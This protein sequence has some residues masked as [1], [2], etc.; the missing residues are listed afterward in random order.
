MNI[1]FIG[2]FEAPFSTENDRKWSFRML[3]H[4]V[5]TFQENKT[6]P[7]NLMDYVD[8]LDLL[9]YSHTHGWEIP[10]LEDV[11]KSFK[12]KKVP[13]IS[14]HL[15]RWAWL[16]RE[17]D[18]GKEATWKVDH[19]FMADAS[20]EAVKLYEKVGVNWT[21]LKPGVS[22]KYCYM[23]APDPVK[24]PH[25]IIFVG[26]YNYHKEYP[27]RPQLIDWLKETYGDRFGHYGGGGGGG[28][29]PTV[30]GHDLNT[31]YATAKIVVGDSC[32]AGRPYYVSDRYY[33]TR[34][35]GGF[36]LHPY[37]PGI[38]NKGVVN[39]KVGDFK[40]LK[41]KIDHCLKFPKARE[42]LRKIGFN[43]VKNN[44]TYTHRAKEIID[45]INEKV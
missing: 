36:L 23:S 1:G 5:V 25:E 34:G 45:V 41:K 40:D 2:N 7:Q 27:F 33:E 15:D 24:Y 42:K 21:W 19:M 13:V 32:F 14:V 31:L 43:R 30:R 17:T 16:E 35:R 44:E 37:I 4:N 39:Y 8:K 3:G 22:A 12:E 18:V 20:P 29:Y 38:E 11:F 10:S 26:S 28:G 9:V 6:S